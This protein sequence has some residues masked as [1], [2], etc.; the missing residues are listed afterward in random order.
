MNVKQLIAELQSYDPDAEVVLSY[1]YGDRAD[2]TITEIVR[3]VDEQ[4][5]RY[6][7]YHNGWVVPEDDDKPGGKRK[8]AVVLGA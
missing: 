6:S 1:E 7:L 8:I 3:S 2:T 5:L 4:E